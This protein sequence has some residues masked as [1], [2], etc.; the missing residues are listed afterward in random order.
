MSS[1]IEQPTPTAP[2]TTTVICSCGIRIDIDN[3][4]KHELSE[5]HI[6]Y[7]YYNT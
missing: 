5:E 1:E 6:I 2:V 4:L 3:R 7:L